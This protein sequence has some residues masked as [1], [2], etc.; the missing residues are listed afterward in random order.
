MTMTIVSPSQVF[1]S[2]IIAVFSLGQAAPQFQTLAQAQ[3]A[4][5]ALW[6]IIDTVTKLRSNRDEKKTF[7]LAIDNFH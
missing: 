2:I 5:F 1:F 3:G 7:C 4:A 6:K